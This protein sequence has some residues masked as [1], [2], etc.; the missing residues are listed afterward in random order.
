MAE[1]RLVLPPVTVRPEVRLVLPPF[2]VKPDDTVAAP[3]TT[4]FVAVDPPLPTVN[5]PVEGPEPVRVAPA[6]PRSKVVE[7]KPPLTVVSLLPTIMPWVLPAVLVYSNWALEP[8]TLNVPCVPGATPGAVALTP[9][10]ST[11][12]VL[13]PVPLTDK[14]LPPAVAPLLSTVKLPVP[15]TKPLATCAVR[16]PAWLPKTTLVF[17]VLPIAVVSP[18]PLPMFVVLKTPLP[19]F[20]VLEAPGLM[21]SVL[22]APPVPLMVWVL[23]VVILPVVMLPVVAVRLFTPVMLLAPV[24]LMLMV[25]ALT[26]LFAVNRPVTPTPPVVL[27]ILTKP[28]PPVPILVCPAPP[29]L[30]LTVPPLPLI[31][32][33]ALPVVLMLVAPVMVFVKPVIVLAEAPA[34]PM[35]MAGDV[36]LAAVVALIRFTAV[37][38]LPPTAR[39]ALP[40]PKVKL[41]VAEPPCNVVLVLVADTPLI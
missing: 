33:V 14:V 8:V 2:T 23:T 21:S 3:F 38:E 17:V 11:V 25:P 5:P 24:V 29:L 32:V 18:L 20:V 35:V 22:P 6:V 41:E 31:A 9:A 16:P 15:G 39:T 4:K 30:M 40:S 13:L 19:M 27:P 34:L 37:P 12:R 7:F 1:V 28:V 36:L 26:P 10:E